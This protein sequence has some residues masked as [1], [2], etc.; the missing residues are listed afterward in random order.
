MLSL[1]WGGLLGLSAGSFA[2]VFLHRYP[3]GE[4]LL[5]PPSRCPRCGHPVR[6]R[7]NIPVLG[8]LLLGGRCR[9]CRAPIAWTYPL[10]EAVF[11]VLGVVVLWRF[12]AAP[13]VW[14]YL[15]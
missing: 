8:W 11:G 4:S 9:D 12:G 2:N 5:T 6:W 3:Q 10:V 15:C 14:V 7:H 1:V 13:R